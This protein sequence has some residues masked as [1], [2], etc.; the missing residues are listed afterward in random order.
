[1]GGASHGQDH[2]ALLAINPKYVKK[3]GVNHGYLIADLE[4]GPAELFDSHEWFVVRKCVIRKPRIREDFR[5]SC[6]L[7]G[8][9][10]AREYP[11]TAS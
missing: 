9:T 6:Q 10:D 1:M 2:L 4:T 7:A 5:Q 8:E 11:G 3:D